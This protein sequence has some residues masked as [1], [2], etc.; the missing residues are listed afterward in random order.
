MG[1]AAKHS[2][3]K[4]DH[5]IQAGGF[6]LALQAVLHQP[7]TVSPPPIPKQTHE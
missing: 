1:A 6:L 4:W 3:A 7:L 2:I 5:A